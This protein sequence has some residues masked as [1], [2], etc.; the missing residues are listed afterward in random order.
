V[1][2]LEAEVVR[3]VGEY[4]RRALKSPNHRKTFRAYTQ[5]RAAVQALIAEM[6]ATA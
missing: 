4:R 5:L 3:L 6:R 2:A 1:N